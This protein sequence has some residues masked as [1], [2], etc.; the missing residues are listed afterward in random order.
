LL[1]SQFPGG[2]QAGQLPAGFATANFASFRPQYSVPGQPTQ[3]F[4]GMFCFVL[5]LF[6]F[7]SGTLVL[8][9]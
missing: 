8:F 1:S 5:F 3:G 6:Y 9:G 2:F 7:Y 4:P